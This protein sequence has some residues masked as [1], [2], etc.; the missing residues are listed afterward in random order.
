VWIELC[1]SLLR[2]AEHSNGG[3]DVDLLGHIP[4]GR[5]TTELYW[6]NDYLP[7]KYRVTESMLRAENNDDSDDDDDLGKH[8]LEE[9]FAGTANTS[10]KLQLFGSILHSLALQVAPFVFVI[11]DLQWLD[12]SSWKMLVQ[13]EHWTHGLM[14]V[15]TTRPGT[16]RSPQ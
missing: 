9:S 3:A 1:A 14:M 15:C 6:L 11:E 12:S 2:T 7:A 8:L 4:S 16:P 10:V 13:S 5:G